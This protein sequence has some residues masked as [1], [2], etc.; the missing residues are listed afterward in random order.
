MLSPEGI[1]VDH[2][3]NTRSVSI[4]L[5]IAGSSSLQNHT[6]VPMLDMLN[7]TSSP[8]L[9]IPRP[10]QIPSSS[11]TT[12]TTEDTKS[13]RGSNIVQ[14]IPGK[15]GY[16][17]IASSNGFKQDEEVLFEYGSHPSDVLFT[18]YGFVEQPINK[19]WGSLRHGSLDLGWL[20]DELWK[21]KGDDERKVVLE[22]I[23]CWR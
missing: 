15:I 23:G 17:L 16:K 12:S 9:M 13:S 3:V 19:D 7:H 18:E 14:L 10:Q 1:I 5:G 20:V 4:P 22:D 8:S 11:I 2:L 6:L 21:E